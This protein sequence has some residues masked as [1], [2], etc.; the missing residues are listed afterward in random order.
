MVHFISQ[1][2]ENFRCYNVV[3]KFA[4]IPPASLLNVAD[5]FSHKF[6][7]E[8]SQIILNE[9][10]NF[11]YD[12]DL[13][14]SFIMSVNIHGTRTVRW[15]KDL[16]KIHFKRRGTNK[17]LKKVVHYR[18][19]DLYDGFHLHMSLSELWFNVVCDSI[20][21]DLTCAVTNENGVV[22]EEDLG[23]VDNEDLGVVE[24]VLDI[25]D[26]MAENDGWDFKRIV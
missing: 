20:Y 18:Y 13:L 9:E 4:T 11:E 2:V 22:E 16:V 25:V 8:D 12:V 10:K 6:S 1:A 24:E 5:N 23:V 19:V 26:E 14:N 17:K 7:Q 3:L 21:R 15:D